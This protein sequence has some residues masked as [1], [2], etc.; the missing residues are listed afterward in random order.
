MGR[1]KR[2]VLADSVLQSNCEPTWAKLSANRVLFEHTDMRKTRTESSQSSRCFAGL[3]RKPNSNGPKLRP[4]APGRSPSSVHNQASSP[5]RFKTDPKPARIH[6]KVVKGVRLCSE[7]KPL[8]GSDEGE[9]QKAGG[10][11]KAVLFHQVHRLRPYS[12]NQ[13]EKP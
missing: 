8:C 5:N 6:I 3:G 2:V 10:G 12:E 11:V 1:F 13:R 4:H 7:V 9:R